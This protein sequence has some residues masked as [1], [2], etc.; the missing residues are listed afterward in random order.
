M[1]KPFLAF[2][3]GAGASRGAGH[4]GPE[5]PPL[6]NELYDRLAKQFPQDWGSGSPLHAHSAQFRQNFEE[7]YFKE[8]IKEAPFTQDTL[9]LLEHLRPL[10]LYFSQFIID[11][12]G[13][14]LYSKPLSSLASTGIQLAPA[15]AG[16]GEVRA[17][18]SFHEHSL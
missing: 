9:T 17:L 13:L 7:T 10:A 15:R 12:T 14:D 6:M 3:L 18:S 1:S 4:V 11:S 2:L 5:D 16:N 8:V